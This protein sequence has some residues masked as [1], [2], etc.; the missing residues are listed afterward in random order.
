MTLFD[1]VHAL[2]NAHGVPHALI[3]AA[4]LAAHGVARSTYDIDLLT[5]DTRVLGRGLRTA[6]DHEGVTVDIRWGDAEDPL[7]G[8]VRIE[9]AGD[10]PVDIILGKHEWQTRAV[11]RA[12]H[13]PEG[14][15]VV[16][17]RDLVLLKLY[18]GGAQ[19]LWDVRELLQL[20]GCG[21]LIADVEADL[22]EQ[23]DA[24]R[25]LWGD[26]RR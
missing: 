10:R 20:P 2:L 11:E 8:V 15:P 16:R 5:T 19:D 26:A 12:D 1:Q 3:G 7:A 21:R 17:P 9:T 4:A 13:G 14:A 24:M 18:A 25:R 6:L 22:D 23:S